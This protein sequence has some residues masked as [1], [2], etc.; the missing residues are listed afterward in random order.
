MLN[1][2]RGKRVVMEG[3]IGFVTFSDRAGA[4]PEEW[5]DDLRI[6]EFPVIGG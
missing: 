1:S 3:D 5:P 2:V 4:D 6:R